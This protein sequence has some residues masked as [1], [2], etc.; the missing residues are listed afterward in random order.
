[1]RKGWESRAVSE[2]WAEQSLANVQSG[3]FT[4][5]AI[6]DDSIRTSINLD[7]GRLRAEDA[8]S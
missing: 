1:M 6:S 3:T 5:T 7:K 8:L 2:R 4:A